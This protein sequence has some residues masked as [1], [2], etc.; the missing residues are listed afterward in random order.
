M[1]IF[2]P[3]SNILYKIIKILNLIYE[4]I[5]FIIIA[6]LSHAKRVQQGTMGKKMW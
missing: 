5:F 1:H 4:N 6:E 2:A 3:P